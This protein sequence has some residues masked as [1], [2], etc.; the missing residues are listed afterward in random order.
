[1]QQQKQ[2]KNIEWKEFRLKDVASFVN[3]RAFKPA[4]WE[5]RGKLI[6]RIQNLTGSIDSPNYTTKIFE[7]RYLVKRGDLLI[8]WSATL[9]AFIWD[10]EEGWL[11]QHIFKVKE[12]PDV[13][14][15]K[16]LFYFVKKSIAYFLKRTH[17][18]TM[19]HIT[20]GNFESIKIPLPFSNG[21]P[22]IK[23]QERIVSILERAEKQKNKSKK[24]EELLDEYLKSVFNEMFGRILP[25]IFDK[26]TIEIIDGDRGVNYPNG[27]DFSEE[28]YCLFLNTGNVRKDGFNLDNLMF[29]SKDKDEQ[30]RKG[31]VKLNDVILTTRGTVGNVALYD[32]SIPYRNVRINSGMVLLRSN[33]NK[34]LP[35][36]L[37]YT[38]QMPLI[39]NQFKK[40]NSGTA[41]P[42]LPI[43]NLKRV[44]IPLPPLPLQQKFAKIVEQ[45]EK[46]KEE[47]KNTK[48][49]SEELF[50]SLM[51]KA[52]KGELAR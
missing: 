30:L 41:Q 36:Y 39:Q 20:K 6:I 31:K 21:K 12:D 9:D 19:K 32:K 49:N 29:I 35:K 33:S 14:N 34:L 8:S 13:I 18:S 5:Q 38:I 51:Q 7:D 10:E 16:Y 42:Q 2:T 1:M 22:D 46:M 17:G 43:T 45:V 52:F 50:N 4:E 40:M 23:E 37:F 3:G 48:Q 26:E 47:V 27:K 44:K 15:R 28:G 24:V 11:N 25:I